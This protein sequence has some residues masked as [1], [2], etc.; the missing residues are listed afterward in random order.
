MRGTANF[1]G[2]ALHCCALNDALID[3][4]EKSKGRGKAERQL[5]MFSLTQEKREDFLK[6]A[7]NLRHFLQENQNKEKSM[8]DFLAE[9]R[10]LDYHEYEFYG[11]FV[12]FPDAQLKPVIEQLEAVGRAE[13]LDDYWPLINN[14]GKINSAALWAHRN[15]Q[16]GCF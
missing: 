15:E 8:A 12:Q 9:T 10:E 14:L 11:F 7:R 5:R 16:G 3:L 13:P 1:L 2:L 6:F 4:S